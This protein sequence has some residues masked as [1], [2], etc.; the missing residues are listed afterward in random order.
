MRTL[1]GAAVLVVVLL[2][3]GCAGG[4][5]PTAAHTTL[6]VSKDANPDS[7]GRPSPVVLRVYLLKQE[8]AFN[9][10][11]YFAL[12]DKEQETLGPSLVSREEYEL[13]PGET[14]VLDLK[15]APEAHF[16][17]LSAGFFDIRNSKWKTITGAPAKKLT[18]NIGKAEVAIA[19]RK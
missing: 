10:A 2:A 9:D 14:R 18:I 4:P 5:K 11:D 3:A 19:G 16:I 1:T 6:A 13:Q 15:V 17:G 7:S 8:G 12:T